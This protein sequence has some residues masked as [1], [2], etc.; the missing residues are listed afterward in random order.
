MDVLFVD[1]DAIIFYLLVFLLTLRPLFADLLESAG[2]SPQTLFARVSPVEAEEQ[3]RVL[4]V[5]Y[6]VIFVPEG[7]LPDVSL[8]SPL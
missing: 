8:S 3:Q 6:S 4:S 2:G 1:V 5:S 7:Y